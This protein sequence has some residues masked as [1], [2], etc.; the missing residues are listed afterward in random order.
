MVIL[1]NTKIKKVI[2]L[3]AHCKKKKKKGFCMCMIC[4]H[5]VKKHRFFACGFACTTKNEKGKYK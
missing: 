5:N 4:P 2:D 1:A 3:L